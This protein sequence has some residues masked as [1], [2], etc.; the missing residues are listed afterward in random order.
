MQRNFDRHRRVRQAGFTLIELMMVILVISILVSLLTVAVSSAMKNARNASVRSEFSSINGAISSFQGIFGKSPPSELII[1]ESA[2]GWSGTD[3][4]TLR[5]KAIIRSLWPQFDFA[6]NGDPA[7]TP[8][9]PGNPV[10]GNGAID[11]NGD[12][13]ETDT[14][15]LTGAECLVFFLGGVVGPDGVC[16]GFSKNPAAPFSQ[17]GTNREGPYLEILTRPDR[18]VDVDGDGMPEMLDSFPG[19]QSPVIYASANDGSGY[20]KHAGGHYP[21]VMVYSNDFSAPT[22][23]DMT[24]VYFNPGGSSPLNP[25]SHQLISPGPDGEYGVGGTY[26]PDGEYSWSSAR[27]PESDNVIHPL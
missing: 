24:S 19:Q 3:T 17:T 14:I 26:D 22:A 13:D 1:H 15:V 2:A 21:A 8:A 7:G 10:G 25:K 5:S 12:G 4:E 27:K 6:T 20:R 16:I 18:L 23:R 9:G 11:L